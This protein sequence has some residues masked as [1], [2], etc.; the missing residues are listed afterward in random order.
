MILL[1]TNND[2]PLIIFVSLFTIVLLIAL[3]VG[4]TRWLFK[5]DEMENYQKHQIALLK[6]ILIELKNN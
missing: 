6:Q 5:I 2:M 3:T 4:I 1:Q